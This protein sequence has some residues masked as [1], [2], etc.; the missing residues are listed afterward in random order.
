MPVDPGQFKAALSQFASGVTVVT[1]RD[2]AGKPLGLTVSAFCSVSL[3]PPLVLVSIAAG[4]ESHRGFRESGRFAVSILGEGQRD[5][6]KRFA[7]GEDRFAG[8]AV[9]VGSTDAILVPGA[10]AHLECTVQAAHPAGDHVL[11]VGLVERA[12]VRPGRPLL[13]HRG[14]YRELEAEEE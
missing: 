7:W 4:S 10:V 12:E 3:D 11:Y 14:A 1:T 6:S 9:E 8:L 5:V 13:Y 2:A